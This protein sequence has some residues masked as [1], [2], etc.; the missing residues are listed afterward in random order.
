MS[1]VDASTEDGWR[2]E[3]VAFPSTIGW[4][5]GPVNDSR[6]LVTTTAPLGSPSCS[7]TEIASNPD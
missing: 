3:I 5:P 7:S 6:L 2:M 4:G 1:A